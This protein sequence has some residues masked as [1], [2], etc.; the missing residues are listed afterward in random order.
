MAD[1]LSIASSIVGILA[2]AGKLIEIL[3]PYISAAKDTPK[4][5]VSVHAE[6]VNSRIILSALHSLLDNLGAASR[7]RALLVSIDDLIAVFTNGVFI[8]SELEGSVSPMGLSGT[9]RIRARMQWA[10]KE[11]ELSGIL[12]RL[13]AFKNTTLLLLNILQCDSDRRAART[14]DELATKVS[15]LLQNDDL[16]RRLERLE[17]TFDALSRIEPRNPKEAQRRPVDLSKECS[18]GQSLCSMSTKKPQ[19]ADSAPYESSNSPEPPFVMPKFEFE[20]ALDESMP[21]RRAREDTVDNSV[22]DSVAASNAWSIFSGISLSDVSILSHIA[23]P[24][25]P[26]DILNAHHY[27]FMESKTIKVYTTRRPSEATIGKWAKSVRRVARPRQLRFDI[28]FE[29][30]VIFLCPP[31]NH[32][33]SSANT[34]IIFIDG[35]PDSLEGTMSDLPSVANPPHREREVLRVQKGAARTADVRVAS[36]ITLLSALQKLEKDSRVWERKELKKWFSS[37]TPADE[38]AK[39]PS[40]PSLVVALQRKVVSWNALP[41]NFKQPKATTTW[42]HVIELAA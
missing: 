21:Y 10:R 20:A 30:P 28:L 22:K 32:K 26:A 7:N 11:S 4:I 39:E 12:T 40:K 2:A 13:Q 34:P 9:D 38:E 25:Y 29:V 41:S 36:Y 33:G 17:D 14:Q 18:E 37:S 42:C 3:G 35:S 31:E 1:P 27:E 5:A 24:V 19:Y 6:V 16:S 15:T 23:I 8:F